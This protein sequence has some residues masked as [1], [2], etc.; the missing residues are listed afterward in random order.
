MR[1][2]VASLAA[3]VAV[4]TILVLVVASYLLGSLPTSVAVG[5]VL[6]G[7]DIRDRGSGNAGAS[8]VLRTFGPWPALFVLVVDVAKG[9]VAALVGQ[10]LRL[11]PLPVADEWAPLLAGLAAIFGH[12]WPLF[13]GFR[14]GKGVATTAGVLLALDPFLLAIGTAVFVVLVAT[15]R[16][17]ALGSIVATA[18]LP[19]ALLVMHALCGMPVA[20]S[21]LGFNL[22]LAFLIAHTHRSNIARL[23]AGTESRI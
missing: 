17:I 21:W 5:R 22:L 12:L 3:E 10:H 14:G 4:L 18:C 13:A 20:R 7:V 6:G 11:D 19:V 15:T 9:C 2:R 16:L 1:R 8:N 23:L